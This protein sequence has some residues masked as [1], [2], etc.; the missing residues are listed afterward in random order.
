MDASSAG[1]RGGHLVRFSPNQTES[2]RI[3]TIWFSL[4]RS[5]K[6]NVS[7]ILNNLVFY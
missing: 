6:P 3:M 7:E 1:S 5:K 4:V 2:N